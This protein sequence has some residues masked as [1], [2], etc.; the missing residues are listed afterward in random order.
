MTKIYPDFGRIK[1]EDDITKIIMTDSWRM[2]VLRAAEGL[3]LT[4]WW[5]GAGFLRNLVWDTIEGRSSKPTLDV[6]LAHFDKQKL[7]PE[8]DWEYDK[9]MKH[10][11]PFANWEVRN[12][13]RMHYKNDFAPY[14]STEDGIAHWVE[15]ATGVA[16]KLEQ[17]KPKYLFCHGTND[18]FGLIARPIAQFQTP[19]LID[20]FYKRVED[21]RWREQWPHL[22]IV[23]S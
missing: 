3:N 9:K 19:E 15:T 6:D 17:G 10:D 4:D 7:A 14:S 18:L 22:R 1:S 8:T 23:T 11:F 21:K 20:A 12:Q 5:I 2:D 16:V 13:A